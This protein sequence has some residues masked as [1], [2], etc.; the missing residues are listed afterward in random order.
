M[1]VMPIQELSDT[2]LLTAYARAVESSRSDRLFIDRH[3]LH[4]AGEKG[5][6][7]ARGCQGFATI[8]NSIAC[9]TAVFDELLQQT[10]NAHGVEL[11]VNLAAGLDTR[12]WRLTLPSRVSW[13]DVDLPHVLEYKRR[14]MKGSAPLCMYEECAADL[15][16]AGDLDKVLAGIGRDRPSLVITEGL[17][18][19]FAVD[20][21][22]SMAQQLSAHPSIGWWITDVA[23][24]RALVLME[25]AWGSLLQGA[26]FQFGP[27]DSVEFFAERG[28][29]EREFRSSWA[30]AQRLGRAASPGVMRNLLLRV[31]PR[32]IREELHRLAGVTVLERAPPVAIHP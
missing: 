8:A 13:V 6:A 23:G 9:R 32:K 10:V 21:V 11:V 26:R 2:A 12:P 28:W 24:P 4:L 14:R 1:S 17:L 3:A 16:I 27:S 20:E 15:T 7:I 31:L 29:M 19:Y 25:K 5:V 18:V 30:E 22:V